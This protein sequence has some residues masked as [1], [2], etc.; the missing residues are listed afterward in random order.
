MFC[1]KGVTCKVVISSLRSRHA[2]VPQSL[3]ST[4]SSKWVVY[5][6]SPT[7]WMWQDIGP[8]FGRLSL[9][10][11]TDEHIYPPPCSW[12]HGCTEKAQVDCE[13]LSYWRE[14]QFM[15]V[16]YCSS[17]SCVPHSAPFCWYYTW[18]CFTEAPYCAVTRLLSVSADSSIRID[19]IQAVSFWVIV[20]ER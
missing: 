11:F 16:I 7:V 19:G 4:D 17:R 1:L 2:A 18:S 20:V 12:I 14:V 3:R 13:C 5:K 10:A 15:T 8:T 9:L 6:M